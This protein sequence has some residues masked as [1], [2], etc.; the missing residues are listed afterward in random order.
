MRALITGGAGFIGSHLAEDLLARGHEVLVI[1]DLSTGSAGNLDHLR[2]DERLTRVFDTVLNRGV[3]LE[4]VDRA[5][6]V[7][8]LAAV[9]GVQLIVSRPIET[10]ETNI[11]LTEQVLELCGRREKPVLITST[12]EVYGKLTKTEFNEDDDL[13]LGPTSRS[14]WS[15]AASK[16]VDEFLI[17]AYHREKG[18]PSVTVRLFNTIGPRQ[19]GRYGMVVPR[20]VRQ[21]LKG[22][23]LTVFGDGKQSRCFTWVKEAVTAMIDLLDCPAAFGEIV[24]IG[25]PAETTI[26]N[27]ANL[28][29]ELTESSSEIVLIP[30]EKAYEKG[31]EDMERRN[32]GLT[33]LKGLIGRHPKMTLVEMLQ[34][35]IA[36]E[37]RC[38]RG[39]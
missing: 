39:D 2:D 19:T 9:V 6:V 23:P 14:R 26:I 37:R 29:I 8:H 30:Y 15:Y 36:Y 34:T 16:I 7:F 12:S 5:D 31:F 18:L 4:L 20:L 32:P 38:L 11:R 21:A 27:L 25:S 33:K 35:I 17:Q 13:V 3:M 24:N 22:D 10:I 1:D 28:I